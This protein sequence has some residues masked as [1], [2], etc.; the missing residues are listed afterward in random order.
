MALQSSVSDLAVQYIDAAETDMVADRPGEKS[1][2]TSGGNSST[3]SWPGHIAAIR[4]ILDNHLLSALVLEEDVDWDIRIKSQMVALA[5][6][7]R[8]VLDVPLHDANQASPYGDDWDVLWLGHCG[9]ILPEEATNDKKIHIISNDETVAPKKHQRWLKALAPYPEQTRIVQTT[10]SPLCTFAYAV[11]H[12]GAQKLVAD[13]EIQS[14][15]QRFDNTLSRFCKNRELG[16]KCV[17]VQP[18]LFYQHKPVEDADV[19]VSMDPNAL[20]EKGFTENIVWSTRLNLKNLLM[21]SENW[22]TQW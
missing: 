17:S 13:M 18:M 15:N 9:D 8:S 10:G 21:G 12:K 16:A 1:Q 11:S 6:G 19:E 20:R 3:E 7:V 5:E 14:N 22:V 4:S 2:A